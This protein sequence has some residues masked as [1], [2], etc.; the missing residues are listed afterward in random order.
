MVFERQGT[1][2]S[3]R[4]KIRRGAWRTHP[5]WWLTMLICLAVQLAAPAPAHAWLGW[6]ERLSGPGP[7][8]TQSYELRLLCFGPKFDKLERLD[9]LLMKANLITLEAP[10]IEKFNRAQRSWS[11]FKDEL[12]ALNKSFPVLPE[13]DVE[14]FGRLIKA[15]ELNDYAYFDSQLQPMHGADRVATSAALP[16]NPVSNVATQAAALEARIFRANVSINSVGVLWSFCSPQE[17]RRFAFEAG[18]TSGQANSTPD[19]AN[20]HTIRLVTLMGSISFRLFKDPRKDVVDLG[21]GVGSYWFSSAGLADN[22]HGL[23]LQQRFDLHG[24]TRWINA[25]GFRMLAALLTLRA[26]VDWFPSGF[27]AH[28]FAA[29]GGKAQEISGGHPVPTFT[30]FVNV[31]PFLR[32]RKLPLAMQ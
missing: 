3:P 19:Y 18:L 16:T 31:E 12:V 8:W 1:A 5:R 32:H 17:T 11:D 2:M 6:L 23:I 21:A 20:D 30:V 27:D 9:E 28:A 10:S 25:S 22:V 7:F 29:T 24:P 15:L 26:G 14:D 4:E 13:A